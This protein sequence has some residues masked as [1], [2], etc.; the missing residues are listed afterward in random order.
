MITNY[1]TLKALANIWGND[2]PGCI[3]GDVYSQS[4]DELTLAL[5]S[6]DMTWMLRASTHTGFPYIFRSEGY[7]KA[8][9]NVASLFPETLDKKVTRVHQ[10]EYDRVMFF[11]LEDGS[12]FQFMLFGPRANILLVDAAGT[13]RNAFQHKDKL[14]GQ[15]APQPVPAPAVDTFEVFQS[16]WRPEKKTIA[17]AITAAFPFFNA[18]LAK[19]VVH[20]LGMDPGSSPGRLA[21][22]VILDIY[23]ISQSLT[24]ELETWH[25]P[26]T[27]NPE[28][29]TNEELESW[30]LKPE[31]PDAPDSPDSPDARIY[32]RDSRAVQFSLVPLHHLA[33]LREETFEHL[34][35][36]VTIYVRRRLGQ[37][38][39]DE[40][41]LPLEKVLESAHAGYQKRLDTMLESLSED[42][43]AD[44]YE[45]WGH[46]LMAGQ[47][48]VKR[49]A[50]E[51]MLADLFAEDQTNATPVTIPLD[52]ALSAVENAQRYYEKAR[53]T[54]QAREYAEERLDVTEKRIFQADRLLQS[55]R[56]L[57]SRDAVLKFKKDRERQLAP[58]L[59]QQVESSSPQIPFR[60][61]EL[62]SGYEV[63]V[64]KNAK[65]NDDLTFRHARKF[66]LWMHARGVPGSHTV[67]R[68]PG[69]TAQ[70]PKPVLEKA[71]SIA[72]FYSKARGSH[73]VPVIV[74][75]RKYVRKPKGAQAG[76]VIVEREQVL[77]VEP[78][79]PNGE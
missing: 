53:K 18:E 13:I 27:Q 65:Q 76:T 52:P 69:K 28:P 44:K 12:Y 49:Q 42:S 17:R 39:F 74:C 16:R 33:D 77:L 3:L 1:Y 24:Q 38:A 5:T 47:S 4:K 11:D 57:D 41:Y 56:K 70:T 46:L 21:P 14:I 22:N 79:L 37:E 29:R 59:G 34:D 32:W 73:L 43:R 35:K 40:V 72:A 61:F 19:E 67:L 78:G 10:A 36:A 26:R 50:K 58:F 54:R 30:N 8:R 75:E 63:W 55:L 62:G 20:R 23:Q 9:R 60:R 31:T 25:H 51:V 15:P 48:E 6:S 2:L 71:A 7:N 64:G 68:R 45:Q 66:D